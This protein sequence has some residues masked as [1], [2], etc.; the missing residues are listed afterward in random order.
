MKTY[1]HDDSGNPSF[2]RFAGAISL[3]TAVGLAVLDATGRGEADPMT[4]GMFLGAAFGGKVWQKSLEQ[5]QNSD[6]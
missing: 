5:K 3:L 2:V 1:L 4:I 6:T